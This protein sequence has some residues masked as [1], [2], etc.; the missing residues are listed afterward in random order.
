MYNDALTHFKTELSAAAFE[1][2]TKT[3]EQAKMASSENVT[4][5][6]FKNYKAEVYKYL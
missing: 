6:D 1:I 4:L 5:I 3:M 2:Q